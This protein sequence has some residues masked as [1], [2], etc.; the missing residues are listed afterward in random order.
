MRYLLLSSSLAIAAA[1]VFAC[2][3]GN[4]DGNFDGGT[5]D[6]GE[7]GV[8]V[9][10]KTI[11]PARLETLVTPDGAFELTFE[12][13]TFDGPATITISRLA[14]RLIEG[15]VIVPTYLASSDKEP[16]LPFQAK[17]IGSNPNGNPSTELVVARADAAG[18]FVPTPMVSVRSNMG[19]T[20]NAFWGLTRKLGTF[21]LVFA[22]YGDQTSGFTDLVSDSCLARCCGQS[23][24]THP[25]GAIGESCACAGPPSLQCFIQN[26]KPS[27]A[28]AIQRCVEIGKSSSL[29]T[30]CQTSPPCTPG[31]GPP[32]NYPQGCTGGF[33]CCMVANSAT[34]IGTGGGACSGMAVRCDLS[35]PCP[36]GT[37]CCVYDTEAYCASSC[38]TQRTWCR[39]QGDC[40]GGAA[41]DGGPE[42]GPSAAGPCFAAK[43]CPHGTCGTP[44]A[45]CTN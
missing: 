32:C 39:S 35:S 27:V 30:T 44:P 23:G 24:G 1:I 21:S 25:T 2:S 19:G 41:A 14:N 10:T 17:F 11:E 40:D 22:P 3:Y 45:A 43:N 42:A 12:A 34:C 16:G 8:V 31:S 13:G 4:Y 37:Q 33:T 9:L 20:A 38:P 36:E 5:G 28:D 26:C 18:T 29:S 6:G 15:N 7:A